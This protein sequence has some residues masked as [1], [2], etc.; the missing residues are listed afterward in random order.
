VL[1]CEELEC[2][3]HLPVVPVTRVK[4]GF[5]IAGHVPCTTHHIVDVVA[6]CRR[7]SRVLAATEAE[8]VGSNKILS[9]EKAIDEHPSPMKTDEPGSAY[10]PLVQLFELARKSRR[11]YKTSDGIT[12]STR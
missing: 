8:L 1:E 4:A 3:A 2:E 6:E 5:I 9:C 11:E 10:R 12:W 7:L